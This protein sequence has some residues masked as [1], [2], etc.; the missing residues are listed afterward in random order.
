MFFDVSY[1]KN[2]V[3]RRSNVE[4]RNLR[5]QTPLVALPNLKKTLSLDAENYRNAFS[6]KPNYDRN[7]VHG[8]R[9][10]NEPNK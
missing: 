5:I 8:N 10:N 1:I 3:L 7:T 6:R 2:Q 4:I 9:M